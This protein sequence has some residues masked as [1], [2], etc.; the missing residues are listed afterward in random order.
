MES[1]VVISWDLNRHNSAQL[2]H[3]GK[4]EACKKL[5]REFL[6]KHPRKWEA[7][8]MTELEWKRILAADE[9]GS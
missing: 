9:R 6:L 2:I 5:E 4:M 7:V 1:W 3:T 8:A